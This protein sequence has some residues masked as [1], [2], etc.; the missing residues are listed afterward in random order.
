[1]CPNVLS[2]INEA[3]FLF[4]NFVIIGTMIECLLWMPNL[5]DAAYFVTSQTT[6]CEIFPVVLKSVFIYFCFYFFY[7]LTQSDSAHPSFEIRDSMNKY[8]LLLAVLYLHHFISFKVILS[9]D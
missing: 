1:M 8:V 7:L 6:K 2:I 9:S 4:N 5:V 3:Q